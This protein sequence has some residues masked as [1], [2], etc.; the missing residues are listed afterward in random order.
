MSQGSVLQTKVFGDTTITVYSDGSAT[1]AR[2]GQKMEVVAA[3]PLSATA[4]GG[5][6]PAVDV[7]GIIAIVEIILRLVGTFTGGGT[8]PGAGW[9]E[10]VLK[11]INFFKNFNLPAPVPAPTDDD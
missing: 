5:P 11:W 2:A 7:A 9:I 4:P 6:L 10:T 8:T 3:A 1:V